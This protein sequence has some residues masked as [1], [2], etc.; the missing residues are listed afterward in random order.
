[1]NQ[2]DAA[3][4]FQF[5]DLKMT[6]LKI[7]LDC[8]EAKPVAQFN[9]NKRKPD[10]REIYCKPCCSV[11]GAASFQKHKATRT[12]KAKAWLSASP[13]KSATYSARWREKNPGGQ[14]RADRNWYAANREKKLAFDKAR[15]EAHIDVFLE[16]ERASYGRRKDQRAVQSKVWRQAN[17]GRIAHYASLRRAAL[18]QR[19]PGWL[20]AADFD[21]I[22]FIYEMAASLTAATGVVHHVD[23]DLPLR[24]R[25]VS[26]LHV[27]E[28]LRILT[29][30]ENLSKSNKWSPD[31]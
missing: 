26:G 13:G 21:A 29:G 19:T 24:G 6:D 17:K 5:E 4:N 8:K 18:A 15:R 23:H 30:Q 3:V 2:N 9:R 25:L 20:T 28:N 14:S 11:R 22:T 1:M 7:C 31:E 10:G 16:R 27:L 12:A